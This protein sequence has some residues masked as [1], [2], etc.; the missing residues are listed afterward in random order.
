MTEYSH[1]DMKDHAF[2][3]A[4]NTRHNFESHF[5]STTG[6]WLH[7]Y[8]YARRLR[9]KLVQNKAKLQES[10]E[11]GGDLTAT[12]RGHLEGPNYTK[13]YIALIDTFKL[14]TPPQ[15]FSSRPFLRAHGIK[16]LHIRTPSEYLAWD[17]LKGSF[18]TIEIGSLVKREADGTL[19]DLQPFLSRPD[20]GYRASIAKCSVD[21]R[22]D[23]SRYKK[24]YV[25]R[26][27]ILGIQE[28]KDWEL[29][30]LK[31]MV[32]A[33]QTFHKENVATGMS[34]GS[35]STKWYNRDKRAVFESHLLLPYLKALE[36]TLP[37]E[38]QFVFVVAMLSLMGHVY[39]MSSIAE[40][41]AKEFEGWCPRLAYSDGPC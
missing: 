39:T 19:S 26:D 11:A 34:Q 23:P 17:E 32:G 30:Q 41:I 20:R 25:I 8:W 33:S 9:E 36:V 40:T 13:V 24:P 35:K 10:L 29:E 18:P 4:T 21:G 22:N 3:H 14:E 28:K 12:Q 27:Q 5:V 7:A 2:K 15:M 37:R 16:T 6:S 38:Q 1:D 31:T